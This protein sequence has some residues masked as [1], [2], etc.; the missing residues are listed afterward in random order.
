MHVITTTIEASASS[1]R[2][3]DVLSICSGLLWFLIDIDGDYYGLLTY[4]FPKD[5]VG[6]QLRG[7]ITLVFFESPLWTE[8]ASP[9]HAGDWSGRPL[10]C[11]TPKGP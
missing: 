5:C 11:R 1:L 6:S 2:R 8:S 10:S 4:G 9:S 7:W 3:S